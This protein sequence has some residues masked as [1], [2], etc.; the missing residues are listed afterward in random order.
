MGV[1][2]IIRHDNEY[3]SVYN[4]NIEM[5]VLEN[6]TVKSG[7]KIGTINKQNILGIIML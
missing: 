1:V 4:G 3:F 2:V 6:T 7:M 5:L